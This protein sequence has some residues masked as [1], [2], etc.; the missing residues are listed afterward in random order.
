MEN[1]FYAFSDFFFGFNISNKQTYR[2]PEFHPIIKKVT[3]KPEGLLKVSFFRW[4]K[5]ICFDSYHW[6]NSKISCILREKIIFSL[7]C[8]KQIASLYSYLTWSKLK[9]GLYFTKR[10]FF[11]ESGS[12]I[13]FDGLCNEC[14]QRK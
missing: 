7:A 12:P 9:L 6:V 11:E 5:K 13:Y 8:K 1:S 10:Y 3:L 2:A 4:W 14:V